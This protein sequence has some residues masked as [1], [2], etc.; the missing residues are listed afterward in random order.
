MSFLMFGEAVWLWKPLT[1]NITHVRFLPCMCPPVW[2]EVTWLCK[3]LITNITHKRFL[4]CMCPPVSGEGMEPCKPLS[5]NITHKRL[6][7]C[8]C[9]P[10]WGE[11]PWHC[12]RLITN[13]THKRFSPVC[14]LLCEVRAWSHANPFRQTSHTYG[15]SP[16]CVLWCV[17]RWC[18]SVNFLLTNITHKRFLPCMYPPVWGEVLWCFKPLTTDVTSVIIT[19]VWLT[20]GHG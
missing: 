10:V 5:T 8:M 9:P 13:I 11:F 6:L 14:V 15:F 17:V 16:V 19:Y 18:D 1:T 12:K 7:P 3:R 20:A 4:P 2:G